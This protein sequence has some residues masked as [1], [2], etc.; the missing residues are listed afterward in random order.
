[1]KIYLVGGAV[2]DRLLDYPVKERDW[3]VV[4]STPQELIAKGFKQV[5]KDFP[6]FLHP[7]TQEEY[8]LA[9]TE[10][11]TGKGY[12]EFACYAAPDVT[13]EDDLKRRDLTINAMA[14]TDT[15]DII[16]PFH[17]QA[18]LKAKWLRHVSPA[19]VEDPLR[20]LRTARFAARYA[21]LGFRVAPETLQL[22]QDIVRQGEV[23]ALVPERVWQE[24][25][26]ALQEAAPQV[27]IEVLRACH[28][29]AI[30]IPE[31]DRLFG[32]PNP[33][34]YHPEIDSG[35]HTLMVLEQAAKLTTDPEIRFAA[36]MHDVGKGLTPKEK[37]PSHPGHEEVGTDLIKKWCERFRVPRD[38]EM[39]A[40]LTARYHSHCHKLFELRPSTILTTL[41]KLD[42]FRKPDRFRQF[43]VACEADS[44]GR[45]GYE[46]SEYPQRQQF[47]TFFQQAAAVP[48]APL[49]AKGLEGKALGEALHQQRIAAIKS[50]KRS[51]KGNHD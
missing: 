33:P 43:L 36:L 13:L 3:V 48:I 29:L 46:N 1:V 50:I 7:E 27:F 5:G 9:R 23:Q 37:W 51:N 2:R 25:S 42:A 18:D 12:T 38:Y 19:F 41:E 22:M 32:V 44:R 35:I 6:V 40:I 30:L 31:L 8:A 28:A 11:K 20:I 15:G 26:R 45:T 49:L 4:G 17:G 24:F 16:D 10:R 39:L 34:Q 14:M 47:D 21:H